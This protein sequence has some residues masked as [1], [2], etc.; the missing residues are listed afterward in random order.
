[1]KDIEISVGEDDRIIQVVD[2]SISKG[3]PGHAYPKYDCAGCPPEPASVEDI[4]A[5]WQDTGQPLTDEEFETHAERLEA[6]IWEREGEDN[7]P[8][9]DRDPT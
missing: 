3:S 2:Y 1:M 8:D 6:A 5:I 9:Y 4:Q 7:T